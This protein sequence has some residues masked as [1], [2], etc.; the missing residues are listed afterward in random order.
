MASTNSARNNSQNSSRKTNGYIDVDS[1]QQ[2]LIAAG[3]AVER[4]ASFY[5]VALPDLHKNQIETRM[6]CIFECGKDQETGDRAISIKTKQ[7]GAVFRC[8]QYGCTVR[9]NLLNLMFLMKHNH[10][11]TAGKLKGSEFKE[12]ATDLQAMIEGNSP[13]ETN[14]KTSVSGTGLPCATQ[15]TLDSN[16]DEFNETNEKTF[17]EIKN[18]PLKDSDNERARELVNLDDRFITDI[19]E[20]SPAAAKYVRQRP[21]MTSEIMK[22]YRCGYLPSNAKGLLRG[23][24]VYGY[25]DA[26]GQILT[27]FGRNLNYEDQHKKWQRHSNNK[28][29]PRKFKFVKGF[30]RGQELFGLGLPQFQQLATK[31]YFEQNPKTGIILVEGQNDA[32]NLHTLGVP[33]L[34]ICSNTITETQAKKL[35]TLANQTHNTHISIMFDLDKEGQTGAKQTVLELA[36][37]CRVRLAWSSAIA[38]GQFN[39]RQ[40]ESI[41]LEELGGMK[42]GF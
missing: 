12:I 10:E 11:P 15:N 40:P 31:E 18:I 37:H 35:A 21:F 20:M 3:D 36:K 22:K 13:I 8:F 28:N 42:Q 29:E 39:G 6:A 4:I 7:D 14:K 9:G 32:I 25:P 38:D 30:H 26:E 27:W 34:A 2:E 24:F 16:P 33:A 1:L 17:D 5:N 41:S 19:A 23:H